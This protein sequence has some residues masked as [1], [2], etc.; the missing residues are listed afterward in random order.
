MK[1]AA[2]FFLA[3]SAM[4]ASAVAGAQTC[5][6]PWTITAAP[7]G[8]NILAVTVCGVYVGCQPH[9]PRFS[10]SGSTISITF[11]TSEPPTGCQCIQVQG[12]FQATVPVAPVPVG[13]YTVSVTLLGCDPRQLVGSANVTQASGSAIPALEAQ[14]LLALAVLVASAGVVLLRR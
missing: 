10:V 1:C 14:G 3:L 7:Y 13:D 12:T 6:Y 2:C 11:Q 8:D 4:A 5:G 9:N